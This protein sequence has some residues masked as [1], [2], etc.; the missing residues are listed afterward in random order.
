MKLRIKNLGISILIALLIFLPFVISISVKNANRAQQQLQAEEISALVT[1][2]RGYYSENIIGR[3]KQAEGVVTP[4]EDFR[5][6]EGCL[7]YTS[8]AAD[9]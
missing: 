2:L 8:D 6:I 4:H 7:L 3:I 9:E 1:K 5:S